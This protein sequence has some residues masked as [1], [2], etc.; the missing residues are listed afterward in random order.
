MNYW[1]AHT[2]EKN[3]KKL[4]QITDIL[5][6]RTEQ[7]LLHLVTQ[8]EVKMLLFHS[9]GANDAIFYVASDLIFLLHGH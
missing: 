2:D 9:M 7:K 1:K 4:W 5:L 3:R 6:I 8:Q